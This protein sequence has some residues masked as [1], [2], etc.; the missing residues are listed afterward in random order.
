MSLDAFVRW[1]TPRRDQRPLQAVQT[2]AGRKVFYGLSGLGDS[3]YTPSVGRITVVRGVQHRGVVTN[4]IQVGETTYRQRQDGQWMGQ[5]PPPKVA[6]AVADRGLGAPF[7]LARRPTSASVAKATPVERAEVVAALR[8]SVPQ[9][10]GA[11]GYPVGSLTLHEQLGGTLLSWPANGGVFEVLI[12]SRFPQVTAR[13]RYKAP[14]VP[15]VVGP[16]W[17]GEAA[18][19]A[20]KL[21][22]ADWLDGLHR[23]VLELSHR[24]ERM[25][26]CP[27]GDGQWQVQGYPT[28][29]AEHSAARQIQ[30][31]ERGSADWKAAAEVAVATLRKYELHLGPKLGCGMYACAY[32]L[33]SHPDTVLKL[34]GDPSDA[35]AWAYILRKSRGMAWPGGLIRTHCVEVVDHPIPVRRV[36]GKKTDKKRR[37][38]ILLQEKGQS[39]TRAEWDFFDRESSVLLALAERKDDGEAL[40]QAVGLAIF[41]EVSAGA[42][43]GLFVTLQW[44]RQIK[45]EWEDLHQGN[46]MAVG[47]G[48]DRRIVIVDL[49][50]STVP[51]SRIPVVAE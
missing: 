2:P 21:F 14:E 38:Y 26:V 41:A 42:I 22:P 4:Q 1:L 8:D 40:L 48:D 5:T 24:L 35:A 50:L 37:M 46:V 44:L 9:V 27:P 32:G 13:G 34:T 16:V 20:D 36:G 17:G 49:G 33:L 29:P 15:A 19:S 30:A 11:G 39:L 25:V 18:R 23:K 47:D 7:G 10:L 31:T 45:V 28:D 3:W 6:A 51:P 12:Q 43:A